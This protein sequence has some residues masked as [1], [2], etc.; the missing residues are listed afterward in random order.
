MIKPLVEHID[1]S[2]LEDKVDERYVGSKFETYKTL[3]PKQK[4]AVSERMVSQILEAIGHDVQPPEN[5]DH[6]RIVNGKKVEIKAA[7]LIKNSNTFSFLQIRPNQD[8]DY[9]IL[10]TILPNNIRLFKMEKETVFG[11]IKAGRIKPQH[12]GAKAN[13]GTYCY[14]PTPVE[15]SAQTKEILQHDNGNTT[16]I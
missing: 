1:F 5:T 9:Y 13:S 4:G 6:D 15:L 11:L 2:I 8:V 16:V 3:A 7:T 12:G 10:A 14:Y